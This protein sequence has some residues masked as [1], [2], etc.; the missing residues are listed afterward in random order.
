MTDKVRLSKKRQAKFDKVRNDK[1]LDP[2]QKESLISQLEQESFQNKRQK[3]SQMEDFKDSCNFVSQEKPSTVDNKL[4]SSSLWGQGEKSF[5]EDVTLNLL[6]DDDA[7][8]NLKGQTCMKWDPVKKKYQLKKVDRDGKVIAEKRN[9]SG[10]KI[11]KKMKEKAAQKE[12]IY[13]KWQQRT[14]LSLQKTGEVEDNKTMDQAK[15]AN[16]AR[17]TLKEFKQRHGQDLYKGEDA[18]SHK[19]LI[20]KK[21]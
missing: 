20:D 11:T 2:A 14:H 3:R 17:K 16:D 1:S 12:S 19:T 6:G 9:E 5:L 8:K 18:R 21:T 15:R 4:N 7:K 13:K 10:A